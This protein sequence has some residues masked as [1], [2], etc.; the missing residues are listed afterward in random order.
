MKFKFSK[1]IVESFPG[2]KGRPGQ[3]GGSVPKGG[4][5][6]GEKSSPSTDKDIDKVARSSDFKAEKNAVGKTVD[7]L[8]KNKKL[9]IGD[10]EFIRSRIW[11]IHPS[12]WK[13]LKTWDATDWLDDGVLKDI[14][15][16]YQSE[17]KWVRTKSKP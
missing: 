14:F 16:A 4:G 11:S 12:S 8:V 13:D 9:K 10:A 5:G 6:G 17:S 1:V 2:H 15:K 3:V 7:K